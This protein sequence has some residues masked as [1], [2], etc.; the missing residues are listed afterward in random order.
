[1]ISQEEYNLIK[2]DLLENSI[3]TEIFNQIIKSDNILK[4]GISLT[5]SEFINNIHKNVIN[6]IYQFNKKNKIILNRDIDDILYLTKKI[7]IKR[8]KK[9][10]YN[11]KTIIDYDDNFSKNKTNKVI[12]SNIINIMRIKKSIENIDRE[13]ENILEIDI[14]KSNRKNIIFRTILIMIL[15]FFILIIWFL[16]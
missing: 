4:L 3:K 7:I 6:N 12:Y 9:N 11:L 16:L 10:K 5:N 2:K 8:M 13:L 1:M 15:I 14:Y